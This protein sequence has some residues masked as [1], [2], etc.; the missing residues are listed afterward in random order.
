MAEIENRVGRQH[1]GK[2][3]RNEQLEK[4]RLGFRLLFALN[5]SA[6]AVAQVCNESTMESMP[7]A[8]RIPLT[9]CRSII[10]FLLHIPH[11]FLLPLSLSHTHTLSL[12]LSRWLCV[13]LALSHSLS[14]SLSL[15][16]TLSLSLALTLSP[17]HL[18]H[19]SLTRRL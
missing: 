7:F 19:L 3:T 17:S 13:S 4:L 11:R 18:S 16:L 2:H 12:S 1:K 6:W 5:L 15:S 8:I 10:L 14:L 9:P